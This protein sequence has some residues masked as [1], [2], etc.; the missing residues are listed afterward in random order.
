[1]AR[2]ELAKEDP[3]EVV[4][5]YESG[6]FASNDACFKEYMK[7]LVSTNKIEKTDLNRV[8]QVTAES[9]GT[10]TCRAVP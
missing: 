4:R 1:M 7:A 6:H 9:V 8:F 10:G 2:Q 3:V 5:R